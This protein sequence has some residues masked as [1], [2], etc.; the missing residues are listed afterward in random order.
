M[1]AWP[2][3][4]SFRVRSLYALNRDLLEEPDSMRNDTMNR[5]LEDVAV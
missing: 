1:I 3:G 2:A 5:D 4:L